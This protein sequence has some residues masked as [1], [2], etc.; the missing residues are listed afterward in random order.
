MNSSLNFYNQV[1]TRG[2]TPMA[3]LGNKLNTCTGNILVF[4]HHSFQ[5]HLP[6]ID[7]IGDYTQLNQQGG[8]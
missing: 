5:N 7:T 6:C 3:R 1:I 2:D 8:N 4:D